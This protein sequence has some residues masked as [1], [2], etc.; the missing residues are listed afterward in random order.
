MEKRT[1]RHTDATS[2]FCQT[3]VARAEVIESLNHVETSLAHLPTG[4]RICAQ[5]L[6]GCKHT[7]NALVMGVKH[8]HMTSDKT[9]SPRC[10]RVASGE[11][12]GR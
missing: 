11:E 4:A 5:N 8:F 7:S 9:K 6:R 10:F 2:D 12:L 1:E 3:R